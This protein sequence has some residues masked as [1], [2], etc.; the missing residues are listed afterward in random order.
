MAA[1]LSKSRNAERMKAIQEKSKEQGNGIVAINLD[2]D[3]ITENP[4]N[5]KVFLDVKSLYRIDELEASG[6]RYWRL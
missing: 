1:N 2:I 5:E 6:M 3:L 4:D